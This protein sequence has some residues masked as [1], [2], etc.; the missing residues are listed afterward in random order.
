MA[1]AAF[2]AYLPGFKPM[3]P[4]SLRHT[5]AAQRV[6]R[7]APP[8]LV[9]GVAQVGPNDQNPVNLPQCGPARRRQHRR[10]AGRRR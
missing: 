2:R 6:Q 9:A 8:D 5:C 1:C 3:C 7:L 4:Y 10:G